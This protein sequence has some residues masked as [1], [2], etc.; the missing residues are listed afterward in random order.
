LRT[1]DNDPGRVAATRAH[2][3]TVHRIVEQA[4]GLIGGGHGTTVDEL[5]TGVAAAIAAV[6]PDDWDDTL[7][8]QLRA[9][10]LQ[11]GAE[12]RNAEHAAEA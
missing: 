8:D 2:L 7:L 3:E 1:A 9:L 6:K 11:A 5:G 10:A 12:L 4:A